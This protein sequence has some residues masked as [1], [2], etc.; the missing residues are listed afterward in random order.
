MSVKVEDLHIGSHVRLT[1]TIEAPHGVLEKDTVFVVAEL[2]VRPLFRFFDRPPRLRASNWP[3]A[4]S[5]EMPSCRCP[6]DRQ[7]NRKTT[8][9]C[10][11]LPRLGCFSPLGTLTAK[12]LHE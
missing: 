3:S 7:K 4:K 12:T 9:S 11:F 10:P 5:L 8:Y 6:V 1:K 2:E